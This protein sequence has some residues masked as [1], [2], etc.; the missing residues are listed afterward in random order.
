MSILQ[1]DPEFVIDMVNRYRETE[2]ELPEAP[3]PDPDL[4]YLAQK[5][6]A[7]DMLL[8]YLRE[9]IEKKPVRTLIEEFIEDHDPRALGLPFDSEIYQAFRA[10][11][12]TAQEILIYFL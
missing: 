5:N 11:K 1:T 2:L 7:V 6:A 10:Q 3:V 9:N 8:D 12:E 4:F